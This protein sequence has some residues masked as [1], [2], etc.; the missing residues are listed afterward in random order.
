MSGLM[1]AM[2]LAMLDNLVVGTAMPTIVGELGGL[3]HLSWV[4]TAYA[5]ATAVST[6]VWAK[7]GDLYGRKGV[8]MASIVAFLAGSALTGL[9]QNM[10]ELIGFRGVQGLGAGGLMV[11]AMAIIADLVPLRERGRYQG[12]M[13]A[14]MPLA[15]IGGPLLGGFLT[16]NFS[17][18]WAFYIN[19]PLGVLALIVVARTMRL[20]MHLPGRRAERVSIDW[21]GT[22][23][24]AA[25]LAALTLLCSWGGSRY[26]WSSAP[27]IT[28]GLVTAVALAAFVAVERRATE[29]VLSLALFRSR[30]FTAATMLTFLTGFAMFGAVTFLPQFQ[31]NVQGASATSSGLQLLPLM[32]GMLAT[33]LLGGQLV[34]RTGRYRGLL[35][36][37]SVLMIAGLA[38]LATMSVTTGQLTTSVYMIV[39]G[40]G[41]GL[42][43]QTTMLVV[44]NS[45]AQRDVGVA[46]GAATLF[47]TIGGS[48]GVSLLGT[49]FA[50]QVQSALPDRAGGAAAGAPLTPGMLEA[51]PAPL[52]EAYQAA[53]TSGIHQVFLGGAAIAVI[54]LIAAWAI[55]EVPLRGSVTT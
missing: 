34:T 16:D 25:G 9:S 2:L 49:L 5:L 14:V 13:A 6:P 40:V 47:R 55:R 17:W 8:F 48:I 52:R 11:G 41:M 32:G 53:I 1:I 35:L 50:Q 46:S 31:Q 19:L 18:R 26:P 12:L 10:G 33:S 20:T 7:L 24:L 43:M 22:G 4:V 27:I 37:G 23:L 45:V 51:L 54:A 38:L 3:A 36:A 39:L 44:Q 21:R 29:P 15:F 30:N 28:L 42:L